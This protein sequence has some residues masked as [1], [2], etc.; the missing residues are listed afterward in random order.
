[1]KCPN[2]GAEIQNSRKCNYCGAQISYA[3]L[4]EQEQLNKAGCPRCGSSNVQFSRENHGEITGKQQK[5]IIHR[6]VG[7]CKD[8]GHTWY[9]EG[10]ENASKKSK[11]WLWVLGWIFIFPVPLTILLL[12]KKDMK[13]ALKYGII[14][15][16]WIVFLLLGAGDRSSQSRNTP[17]LNQPVSQQDILVTEQVTLETLS[18]AVEETTAEE[19]TVEETTVEE[20]TVK[21]TT[22][23]KETIE[24]AVPEPETPSVTLGEQNALRKA[25]SYL[26]FAAFSYTG[27]IE[28][29]EFEGFS[30]E[31]AVYGADNC[32]ADWNAQ[33]AKKAQ[34]YMD[35]MAFSR[36]DLIEQLLYEGFTNEQA[37][38]GASAVG[39]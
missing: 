15:A 13:P 26:D 9:P 31:E 10:T 16:S 37:E 35:L 5:K 22:V 38:Y 1:M 25:L 19:T 39:Y 33:A 6:T 21:E 11:T 29:L 24:E 18:E 12:R 28:Q 34:N 36:N 8:C 32:G 14:A 17:E 23:E 20:T 27:L 3:Q 2:C 4:R 30:H 7:F